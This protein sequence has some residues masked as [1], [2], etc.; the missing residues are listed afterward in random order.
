MLLAA[1]SMDGSDSAERSLMH[2]RVL[3]MHDPAREA[4]ISWSTPAA[5][6]NHTVYYDVEPRDGRVEAYVQ[7]VEATHNGRFT[8]TGE[9]E[10]TPEAY[11]HHAHLD[12]LEPATTYHLV[13]TSDGKVSREFHFVT[14][15]DDER[16]VKLLFG[17]DSRR[18][19]SLP[20]PHEDRKAMNRRIAALVEEHPD[21]VALAHGG[22][23]CSRAQWRFMADWLS[24]HELT[25]TES[26]RL[27][28]IIPARGNHDREI[29]FEEMF[30]WPGREHNYYYTTALSKRAVILTLNTEISHAGDQRDWLE[31][32]L[33]RQRSRPGKWVLVQYHVPSYGT[34]KSYQQGESQRRHW[35]PLFEEFQVD[36]VC[37]ADHHSL[38]R[39]VPIYEDKADPERGV[40]Y[41]GDG[42]LG[43]PQRTPDTTRWYLQ[44]PGMVTSAHNVHLLEFGKDELRGWAIGM[45]G[46]VLD[47]FVA[48]VRNEP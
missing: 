45:E 31:E 28:P 15:P 23:Y 7:Q 24:D 44:E 38:K 4:V 13:M 40:M 3:W 27:L 25:I 19:P 21:I 6:E 47:R 30:Y 34:V 29:V 41:I 33:R 22:D 1:G 32:E 43:V 8:M 14:A 42:G 35:V 11:Y 26:G 16:S 10:G 5:G 37:E 48:K 39:T 2:F 46:A 17:G 12:G 9:D 18:P 36:L 20:E